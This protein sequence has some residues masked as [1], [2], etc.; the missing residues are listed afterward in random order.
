MT[1]AA[2]DQPTKPATVKKERAPLSALAPLLPIALRHKGRI[3]LAL[4][5]LLL[6]SVAT[7]I[8]P[9]AVRRMIDYGFSKENADLISQYFAGLVLVVTVLAVASSVRYYLVITIGERVVADLRTAVF[10]HLTALDAKFYDTAKAGEI[11]SRLTA[12]TTQ[13]KSAFGASASIALRNIV[14][15]LGAIAMMV[16]SSPK[17]AS[18]VLI[19]I[20][21][22]VLPL[23]LAAKGVRNR[24]RIAQDT[25]ADAAGF[26]TEQISASRTMQAFGAEARARTRFSEASERSY[27]AARL[28]TQW[29]AFLSGVGIF[30]VFSS[31]VG[32]LWVGAQAVI[33]NEISAGLLSQFVLYAVFAAS[34]LG[35]L[36][37]VYGEI[38]QAAGAA[39]RLSELLA[40]QASVTDPVNPVALPAETRGEIAFHNVS[41]AYPTRSDE[42]VVTGLTFT[43]KPGERVAIVGPSG[44][45]KSTIF[46]LLLRFY[47]PVAGSIT[48]DGVDIRTVTLTDL[49]SRL[50]LVAQEPAI[51][52]TTIG[53]NIRYAKPD[54]SDEDVLLAARQAAA[55]AYINRLQDGYE[56]LIG[57][58]GITLSGGE[59][60]RL[61]I[62]RA[63]LKD[64]PILLL[65]EATSALDAENE[66]I[67]QDALEGLMKGRTSLV[68]AHRLATVLNA[69]RIIVMDHGRIVEEGTHQELVQKRGL[70]A[71][72]AAL[73]F[74]DGEVRDAAE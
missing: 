23:V 39:S 53:D 14:L 31:V 71:R 68:I 56:T 72:L 43:V 3:A 65:D 44:A 69:D 19:A 40:E 50:A 20:P 6:A 7:L 29:R 42:R 22:I 51:F 35:Q 2:T 63:I 73:Q 66:H 61:A 21:L 64:A 37:E 54:A 70:Y 67:V 13:I 17:L 11:V 9:A 38:S 18:L 45:G 58:R 4:V 62:A 48:I 34:S 24:S 10:S 5:A 57:E 36:S 52:A 15:F 32:V 55:D 28:S 8:V 30:L 33:A 12:D 26:A 41:F 49:R 59:R 16:Y 74:G 60:Q 27:E 47:D 25:L 46:Q 1:R